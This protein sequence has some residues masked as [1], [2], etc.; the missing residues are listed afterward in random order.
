MPARGIQQVVIF[1]LLRSFEQ[2]EGLWSNVDVAR[3]GCL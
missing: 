2:Q 1:G 3:D